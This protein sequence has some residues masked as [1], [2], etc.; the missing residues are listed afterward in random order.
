MSSW[1]NYKEY[2]FCIEERKAKRVLPKFDDRFMF[3]YNADLGSYHLQSFE[4]EKLYSDDVELFR[5][6][7]SDVIDGSYFEVEDDNG[8]RTRFAFE[9]G[10]LR[11]KKAVTIWRD[12][13]ADEAFE[14]IEKDI[15]T[16]LD[17]LLEAIQGH[18]DIDKENV[19]WTDVADL[20]R[21]SEA[22]DDMTERVG[23]MWS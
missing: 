6:I 21:I 3:V 8:E 9:S 13:A 14:R 16:K 2:V 1:Y 17:I 4:A 23:E 20:R 22:L 19:T 15:K 5:E 7:A 10:V 12:E 11:I 18:L